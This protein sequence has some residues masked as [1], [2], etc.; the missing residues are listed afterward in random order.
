MTDELQQYLLH[1]TT[2]IQHSSPTLS[3]ERQLQTSLFLLIVGANIHWKQKH[4][5][6]ISFLG[7]NF[8]S[9]WNILYFI[10]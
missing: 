2:A 6:Q 8:F 4:S 7:L 1:T 9:A 10:S 5:K 3:L